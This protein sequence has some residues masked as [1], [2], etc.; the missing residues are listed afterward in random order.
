MK[1]LYSLLVLLVAILFL[2]N[3]SVSVSERYIRQVDRPQKAVLFFQQ[4]DEEIKETEVKNAAYFSIEGFS[5]LRVNR[6]LAAIKDRLES[7]EQVEFWLLSLQRLDLQ[8]RQKEIQNLPEVVVQRLAKQFE[9]S[10]PEAREELFTLTNLYSNQLLQYDRQQQ[11]FDS[12]LKQSINIP[13]EYSTTMRVFGLYALAVIP[14]AA[15]T[16]IVYGDLQERHDTPAGEK[17]IHGSLITYLPQVQEEN[18]SHA[19]DRV[20]RSQNYNAFGLPQLSE[21]EAFW[22]AG[23]FAPVFIQDVVADYDKIGRVVWEQE[24]LKINWEQPTIYYYFS[25]AFWREKAVLQINYVLWTA[26]RAGPQAPW[27]ERGLIDGIT[28]RVSL[29]DQGTPFLVDIMNSC[30]CYHFFVPREEDFK[31]VVPASMEFDP[32]VPDFLP[33][34]FPQKRLSIRLNTGW[35]QV[36]NIEEA[37]ENQQGITYELLPYHLL[38]SIVRSDKRYESMF[39]Q[40][41]ITKGSERIEPYLL[42][43]MGIPRVGSIRQRGHHPIKLIGRAYFDDPQLINQSLIFSNPPPSSKSTL[44]E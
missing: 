31:G 41:G 24:V 35:H 11:G 4:L 28:L 22:L 7:P 32:L 9:L 18:S 19:I 25:S 29:D 33:S 34:S 20:F 12:T 42:F 17:K 39:D 27:F 23:K 3:C 30:G 37:K 14:V 44:R 10:S 38:E 21:N 5:Y 15:V 26:A 16:Q 40:E 43:S 8:A 36:E 1:N 13:E 6:F 2:Q